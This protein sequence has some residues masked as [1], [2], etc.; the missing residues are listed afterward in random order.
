MALSDRSGL[1][2]GVRLADAKYCD[3]DWLERLA[4]DDPLWLHLDLA[5]ARARDWLKGRREIP[6]EACELLLGSEVRIHVEL[7]PGAFAAVLGDL[8]HDFD[9]DPER[10]GVLRLYV[11]A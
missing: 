4:A 1:I 11:D 6:A 3:E 2:W 7:L 8:Y 9:F 10:L 5:D